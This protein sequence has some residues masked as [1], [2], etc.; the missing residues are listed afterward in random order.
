MG[1]HSMVM[2]PAGLGAKD[3]SAVEGLEHFAR[4]R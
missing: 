2:S 1:H 4:E 3:D